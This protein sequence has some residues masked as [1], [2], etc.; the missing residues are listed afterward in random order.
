MRLRT[1]AAAL[2]MMALLT[3]CGGSDGEQAG[4]TDTTEAATGE[5]PIDTSQPETADQ[6]DT[7]AGAE[8][9]TDETA[10]PD[11]EQAAAVGEAVTVGDCCAFT[12][13]G[14]TDPYPADQLGPIFQPGE[15]ERALAVDVQFEVLEG[16]PRSVALVDLTVRDDAGTFNSLET[17]VGGGQLEY[18]VEPGTPLALTLIFNV[19]NAATGLRLEYAPLTAPEPLAVVPLS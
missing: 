7:E 2:S 9:A 15:D 17:I 16:E 6:S 19:G 5:A 4:G 11:P 10:A 3:A 1:S 18:A 8:G 14:V 13:L 12:V